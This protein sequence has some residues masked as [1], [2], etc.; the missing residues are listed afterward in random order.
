MSHCLVNHHITGHLVLALASAEW[1]TL[2]TAI[3]DTKG[4]ENGDIVIFRHS[5]STNTAEIHHEL[6]TR[7]LRL[8]VTTEVTL[9]LFKDRPENRLSRDERSGRPWSVRAKRKSTQGS[10]P[11]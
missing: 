4:C 6:C 7:G 1:V 9:R 3:Y 5:N 11:D 2:S 10:L 8:N